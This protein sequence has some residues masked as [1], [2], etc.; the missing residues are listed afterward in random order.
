MTKCDMGT[1]EDYRQTRLRVTNQCDELEQIWEIATQRTKYE[2]QAGASQPKSEIGELISEARRRLGSDTVEVGIFGQ[3]KRG[4]SSLI[5][6][7]VGQRVSSVGVIPET[8]K[9][10]WVES[11]EPKSY[12]IYTDGTREEFADTNTAA[13][14]ATQRHKKKKDE[15]EVLRVQQF[16]EIDWLPNGLR[17]VDTPGLA[18]PSMVDDYELRT[19]GELDRVAAAIFVLVQPPGAEREEVQLLKSLGKKGIDKVFIVVNF[20]SDVWNNDSERNQ[21]MEYIR[22]IVVEGAMQ[23]AETQPSSVQLYGLNAKQA[24]TATEDGDLEAFRASGVAKLQIDLEDYLTSGALLSMTQR[25]VERLDKART[26]AYASLIARKQ[27]LENPNL[28]DQAVRDK[29]SAITQSQN[30]IELLKS[31]IR[32]KSVELREKLVEILVAPYDN[33]I[34]TM[35]QADSVA[36]AKNCEEILQMQLETASS[37]ASVSFEQ[38][39][40]DVIRNAEQ[41]LMASFGAVGTFA[42]ASSRN[43]FSGAEKN[44]IS[45]R[46]AELSNVDWGSVFTGS[47][48]AGGATGLAVGS[49]SGGVGMALIAAG[50]VGWIVGAGIGLALGLLGGAAAGAGVSYGKLKPNDRSKIIES[51]NTGREK[52]RSFAIKVANDWQNETVNGLES[53]RSRYLSD[54]ERDLQLI[55]DVVNDTQSRNA[56]LNKID[57]LLERMGS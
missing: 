35:S 38:R 46:T 1:F 19:L 34:T 43:D 29:E 52:A 2:E 25:A 10:V 4:K 42:S 9:P 26:I 22:D 8:A 44:A 7:L 17:L 27:V 57:S 30:E 37:K 14:M 47:V 51:L 56:A 3:V 31:Y 24:V 11:G 53:R 50:P 16:L 32:D 40:Q 28:L 5:N 45:L 55:R 49:I 39:T 48:V 15:K 12:V 6:A 13:E 33:A 23:N 20:W 41:R 21:V 36:V 18:D 54:K